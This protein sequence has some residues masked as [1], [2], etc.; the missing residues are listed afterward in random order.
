MNV[1][2]RDFFFYKKP[3]LQSYE[4]KYIKKE[5]PGNNPTIGVEFG[6]S[7]LL[8]ELICICLLISKTTKREKG[9][10]GVG[11]R[12]KI[13]LMSLNRHLMEHGHWATLC[14]S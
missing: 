8:V 3:L 11:G 2:A 5:N 6:R 9:D 13:D 12:G 1:S 4:K 10:Y 14:L 7:L